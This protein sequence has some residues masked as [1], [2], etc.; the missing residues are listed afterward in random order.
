[1]STEQSQSSDKRPP[2]KIPIKA[3]HPM[4]ADGQV[5]WCDGVRVGFTEFRAR[6]KEGSFVDDP[7]LRNRLVS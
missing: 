7:E 1:M 5:S 3:T 2:R 4:P 6:T